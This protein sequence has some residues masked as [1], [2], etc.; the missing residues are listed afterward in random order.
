MR[1]NKIK[2]CLKMVKSVLFDKS[3]STSPLAA[4]KYGEN[5]NKSK[6]KNCSVLGQASYGK[7]LE[8]SVKGSKGHRES[9]KKVTKSGK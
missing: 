7:T 8:I 9:F 3:S 5:T 6:P 1:L 2:R 4:R